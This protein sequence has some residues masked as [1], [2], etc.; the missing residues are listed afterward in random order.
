MTVTVAERALA[1][2]VERLEQW[3]SGDCEC[4]CCGELRACVV[5]C[6]FAKDCPNEYPRMESARAVLYGD[7]K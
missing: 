3:I 6:T 2:R 7:G 5:G 4:P 1:K